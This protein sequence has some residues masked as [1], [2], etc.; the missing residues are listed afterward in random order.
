[1]SLARTEGAAGSL[2]DTVRLTNTGGTTCSLYGYP[3]VSLVGHGNGTQ[4]GAAAE[5]DRSV[6][7]TRVTVR[8]GTSTTFVV[9]RTQALNYPRAT[10]SP[11]AADGYRIYPPDETAALFL[12]LEGATG[13]ANTSVDLLTVRPVGATTG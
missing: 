12:P 13:C 8:P 1:V 9:R 3:G 4:I 5:R 11:T 2:Y 6:R 10:C 7:R